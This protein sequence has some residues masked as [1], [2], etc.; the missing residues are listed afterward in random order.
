[1][2]AESRFLSVV[3]LGLG[4]LPTAFAGVVW[5]NY[6]G[7]TYKPTTRFA[8]ELIPAGQPV[9]R[10][11][12]TIDDF[13]LAQPT[14]IN[15]IEW[16]GM[17]DFAYEYPAAEYAFYQPQR[18]DGGQII[19][20]TQVFSQQ[21]PYLAHSLAIVSD[22]DVYRA[23]VNTP[24]VTL[25]AGE[26]FVGLRLVGGGPLAGGRNFAVVSQT[27]Q[28]ILGSTAYVRDPS[29]GP[30]FDQFAPTTSL[31]TTPIAADVAFRLTGVVVPEP[32]TLLG[33]LAGVAA[34]VRRGRTFSRA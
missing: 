22:L 14:Q 23:S 5:D 33:L 11:A 19:G 15:S 30:P 3:V 25:P 8:S 24:P 26:Y 9:P 7:N 34:F 13:F 18:D 29:L 1:M 27:G 2:R 17:R 31:P 32:A 6:P 4:L 20:F 16:I 21:A 10:D 28:G 12:L